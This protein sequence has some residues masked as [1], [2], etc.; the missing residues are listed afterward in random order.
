MCFIWL[1]EFVQTSII[2]ILSNVII[3]KNKAFKTGVKHISGSQ[4]GVPWMPLEY[5]GP[6]SA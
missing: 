3:Y 2:Y 4:S 1:K 6:W 5:N